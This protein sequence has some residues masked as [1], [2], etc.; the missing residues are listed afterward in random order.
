MAN[1]GLEPE[2]KA[3]G[4]VVWLKIV[5][6]TVTAVIVPLFIPHPYVP[7]DPKVC[8]PTILYASTLEL[9]FKNPSP[10][11][12]PEQT[13]SWISA[14]TYTYSDSV[15]MLANKVSHLRHDQLPPLSDYDFARYLSETSSKVCTS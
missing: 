11:P 5:L 6:L 15:I 14:L 8:M 7:V 9:L 13:A 3:E 10:V 2:D 12:N 1:Y 4:N